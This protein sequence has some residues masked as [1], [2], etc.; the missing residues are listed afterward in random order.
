MIFALLYVNSRI[1]FLVQK[2]SNQN[3]EVIFFV[4]KCP[5]FDSS[6]FIDIEKCEKII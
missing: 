2:M 4:K 6:V 5:I 1:T 3:F